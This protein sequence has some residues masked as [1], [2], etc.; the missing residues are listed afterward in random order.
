MSRTPQSTP[1]R[2]NQFASLQSSRLLKCRKF[3]NGRYFAEERACV[4]SLCISVQAIPTA[5]GEIR[6][7][8]FYFLE[9]CATTERQNRT[10]ISSILVKIIKVSIAVVVMSVRELKNYDEWPYWYELASTIVTVSMFKIVRSAIHS[11]EWR[12]APSSVV[13]MSRN[14]L[15]EFYMI[16]EKSRLEMAS[17]PT[18]MM[19]ILGGF[20][21]DTISLRND[22]TLAMMAVSLSGFFYRKGDCGAVGMYTR[23]EG[24]VDNV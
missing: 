9:S 23:W 4:S 22:S 7:E 2:L 10:R 14:D 16:L 12:E 20:D 3:L 21:S 18:A 19:S 17:S 6:R 15:V 24:L 1:E 13:E 8:A 11:N 5:S